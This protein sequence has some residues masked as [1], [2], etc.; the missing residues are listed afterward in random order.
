MLLLDVSYLVL[1]MRSQL[2]VLR[3]AITYLA[4][5]HPLIGK[6][7]ESSL[8]ILPLYGLSKLIL[9]SSQYLADQIFGT[10]TSGS[11][12]CYRSQA[13]MYCLLPHPYPHP[14]LQFSLTHVYCAHIPNLY[15]YSNADSRG[16]PK[17]TLPPATPSSSDSPTLLL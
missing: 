8:R 17:E 1:G 4:Q 3:W 13:S 16:T 6:S 10:K 7:D 5:L 2:I 14:R 9:Y 15:S 11:I 12:D